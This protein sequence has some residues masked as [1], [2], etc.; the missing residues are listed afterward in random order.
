MLLFCYMGLNAF[1]QRPAE[2]LF[3]SDSIITIH[4]YGNTS[5]LLKDIKLNSS[6]HPWTLTMNDNNG[7]EISLPVKIKTRGQSR[8]KPDV[9]YYP[10]LL[11]N[12][13]KGS[14]PANCIFKGQDKLKI[15]ST[16]RQPELL[17]REYLLYK[18][19]NMISPRSFRVR[20]MQLYLHNSENSSDIRFMNAFMVESE[21]EMARRNQMILLK[22]EMIKPAALDTSAFLTM[23][24]FQFMIANTDWSVQYLH[25]INLLAADSFAIPVPV[26]FDF[27]LSGMVNAPYA[28]P[29]E[30]LQMN[31]IRERR[32]RGYCIQDMKRY[33]RVIAHYNQLRPAIEELYKNNRLLSSAQTKNTLKYLAEFYSII[34][35]KAAFKEYFSYPCKPE[36]TGNVIIKGYDKKQ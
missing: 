36:G 15:V 26:P 5:E 10:P 11:L 23:A 29:V 22:Q 16:C 8:K 3:L 20:L 12:F 25:N 35:D 24:M 30:E 4:L 1:S 21:E 7:K 34:N 27:D 17:Y 32:Y 28:A 6:Y 9:C 31:S 19:Y 2:Q 14:I 33:D 13:Q 18:V